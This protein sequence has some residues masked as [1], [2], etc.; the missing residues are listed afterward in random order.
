MGP[1]FV[2]NGNYFLTA[3]PTGLAFTLQYYCELSTS[4][5]VQIL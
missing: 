4:P 5:A 1:A 2:A 3:A